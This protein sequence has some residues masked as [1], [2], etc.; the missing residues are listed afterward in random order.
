MILNHYTRRD[1]HIIVSNF[2]TI[3]LSN[4][5]TCQTFKL[6]NF[7]TFT[8]SHYQTNV[9]TVLFG[10]LPKN[11]NAAVLTLRFS[12]RGPTFI[13]G[14]LSVCFL[15]CTSSYWTLTLDSL[16]VQEPCWYS[17]CKHAIF[18]SPYLSL[19]PLGNFHCLFQ[20]P[21]LAVGYLSLSHLTKY[22]EDKLRADSAPAA[23]CNFHTFKLSKFQTINVWRSDPRDPWLTCSNFESLKC[24]SLKVWSLKVVKFDGDR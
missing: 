22:S 13:E 4:S 8:L 23:S 21:P 5:H 9:N 17:V 2:Q 10:F 6:S 1:A 19:P 16:F 24:E 14:W 12:A 20:A 3:K 11:P 7:H 15:S 18:I